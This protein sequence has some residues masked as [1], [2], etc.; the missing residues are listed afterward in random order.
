MPAD[1]QDLYHYDKAKLADALGAIET[2]ALQLT[3][4]MSTSERR[5]LSD[6]IHRLCAIVR[7]TLP[8]L[9]DDIVARTFAS[10]I[11]R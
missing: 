7:N 2:A 5:R 10:T 9:E 4:G 1:L 3:T 6:L 8:A 11:T